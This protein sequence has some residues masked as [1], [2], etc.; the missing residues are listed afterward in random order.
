MSSQSQEW[1]HINRRW[2]GIDSR[3]GQ[4]FFFA[5]KGSPSMVVAERRCRSPRPRSSFSP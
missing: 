1:V 3:D 2:Y 5:G 4:G